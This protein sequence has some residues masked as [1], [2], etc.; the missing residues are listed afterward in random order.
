[1]TVGGLRV[2]DAKPQATMQADIDS[3]RAKLVAAESGLEG[4]DAKAHPD[5]APFM[6]EL[7]AVLSETDYVSDFPAAMAKLESVRARVPQYMALALGPP[8]VV[9][10]TPAPTVTTTTQIVIPRPKVKVE[11]PSA[12]DLKVLRDELT[13]TT[14][15]LDPT[16]SDVA[17]LR[18]KLE[19]FALGLDGVLSSRLGALSKAQEEPELKTFDTELHKI[20]TKTKSM[21]PADALNRLEIA[22]VDATRVTTKMAAR[23]EA[24]MKEAEAQEE[25]LLLGELMAL[26]KA[27]MAEQLA[28]CASG[29]ADSFAELPVCKALLDVHDD[30]SPLYKQATD[31]LNGAV[32]DV[33]THS[34][35]G[36]TPR[37]PTKYLD[38]ASLK[39]AVTASIEQR[40]AAMESDLAAKSKVHD[41]RSEQL[42]DALKRS[43][44]MQGKVVMQGMVTR[45]KEGYASWTKDQSS[46]IAALRST[47]AAMKHGDFQAAVRSAAKLVTPM[48]DVQDALK[49]LA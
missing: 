26:Q 42:A 33:T 32:P 46:D 6:K 31:F 19:A 45:E 27:P 49:S 5:V 24:L 29:R 37:E 21:P 16:A 18:A 30:R 23:Q 38:R 12:Q 9:T 22:E 43:A 36:S 1:M 8:L 11:A 39:E 4:M 13:S 48:S 7:E 47:L 44:A 34:A 35:V 17:I 20:L 28:V 25:S 40:L 41:R 10:T 3:L 14:S 2:P 15:V